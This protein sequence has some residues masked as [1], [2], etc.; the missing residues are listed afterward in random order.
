MMS[1]ARHLAWLALAAA[2]SM[3]PALAMPADTVTAGEITRVAFASCNKQ[4]KPQPAWGKCARQTRRS[5][6]YLRIHSRA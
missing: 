1:T 4:W 3:P 6:C 5:K 2:A